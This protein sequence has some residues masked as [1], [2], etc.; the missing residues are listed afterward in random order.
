MHTHA[1]TTLPARAGPH[2]CHMHCMLSCLGE[3]AGAA[4]A[5]VRAG[6]AGA[7]LGSSAGAAGAAGKKSSTSYARAPDAQPRLIADITAPRLRRL[8]RAG[9]LIC[10]LSWQGA[11]LRVPARTAVGRNR[12]RALAPP[13]P[14]FC[15]G[16]ERLTVACMA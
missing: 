12:F 7:P 6:A 4:W 2:K 15:A 9:P 13:T 16:N 3:R 10:W 14:G 11:S 1:T 5:Q 8:I